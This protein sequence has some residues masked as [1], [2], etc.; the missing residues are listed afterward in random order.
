MCYIETFRPLVRLSRPLTGT[1]RVARM[2]GHTIG[3]ALELLLGCSTP[4]RYCQVRAPCFAI[5]VRPG[6]GDCKDPA[7]CFANP[8]C[9][10]ALCHSGDT[11]PTSRYS[12]SSFELRDLLDRTT[13]FGQLLGR[14]V[15]GLVSCV[16]SLCNRPY[17]FTDICLSGAHLYYFFLPGLSCLK[18]Y[19]LD[20]V[21]LLHNASLSSS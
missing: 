17:G 3:Y 20:I 9:A 7:L 4:T 15:F 21:L 8:V 11:A 18:A 5:P 10:G 12:Y 19:S 1:K 6:A 13:R 16:R 2:A 14:V